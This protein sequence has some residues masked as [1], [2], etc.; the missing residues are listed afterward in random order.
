[1]F[2]KTKTTQ[3]R[4][5]RL[6][7]YAFTPYFLISILKI[8]PFIGVIVILGLLYGLYILYLGI[9]IMLGTPQDQTVTYF[10]VILVVTFVVYFV[11][12]AI[13]GGITLAAFHVSGFLAI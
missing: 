10:V 5:T 6:A 2:G 12:G 3:A 13:I 9:P 1:M 8:V 4:A 11:I 7:A